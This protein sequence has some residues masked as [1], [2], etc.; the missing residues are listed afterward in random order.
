MI[1]CS[2]NSRASVL[3]HII[4]DAMII[5]GYLQTKYNGCSAAGLPPRLPIR[6]LHP[7]SPL[8]PEQAGVIQAQACPSDGG[9]SS[10]ARAPP[11]RADNSAC[12]QGL[13]L[14]EPPCVYSMS[15][16]GEY[17]Q[18]APSRSL[19]MVPRWSGSVTRRSGAPAQALDRE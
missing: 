6:P 7:R 1:D 8:R 2:R 5:P 15:P 10:S 9:L 4:C 19:K 13:G 14:F 3:P 11:G 18:R 16:A 17:L 12:W